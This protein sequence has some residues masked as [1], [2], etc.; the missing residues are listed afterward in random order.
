MATLQNSIIGGQFTGCCNGGL[1]GG[2][3]FGRCSMASAY[4]SAL[5]NVAFGAYALRNVTTGDYNTSV[6]FYSLFSLNSGNGNTAVGYR[7]GHTLT[8][9]TCNTFLG[10]KT[11]LHSLA[12][13]CNRNTAVGVYA[14]RT[15][16]GNNNTAI[17]TGA[18][19]HGS[20]CTIGSSNVGI[21][22]SGGCYV[23][24]DCNVAIGTTSK[25]YSGCAVNVGC[26][27][28]GGNASVGIG[29]SGYGGGACSIALGMNSRALGA[30]TIVIGYNAGNSNACHIQ[31]GNS[32]NNVV[33]CIW[34]RWTVPSDQRD[35][36]NIQS[37]DP[38]YGIEFIK[39]LKPKTFNWDNRE[40]YV[41]ECGFE[42]GQKDGT[43]ANS[44][45]RYGFI[46]Q[47]IKETINELGI[48][49]DALGGEENDAYRV[50]YSDF[51][52]PM[53]KT[54][55]EISERLELLDE[56]VIKLETL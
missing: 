25:A 17:G 4:A 39:K 20:I 12:C 9:G 7:A 49:F 43:L 27:R 28:Y 5:N 31:W 13:A 2:L 14:L 47:E 8:S 37:L 11:Y 21:G 30:H 52:A 40:T 16:R 1:Q 22:R 34:P 29:H 23:T 44:E 38:K 36:A 50:K 51:I 53:I 55:Q 35:K 45:E 3:Q 42:F 10:Y 19:T 33:N 18:L 32:S 56:E 6:G 46:A 48:K 41:R 15:L 26:N 24:G 54:V